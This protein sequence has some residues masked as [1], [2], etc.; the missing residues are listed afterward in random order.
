MVTERP[1]VS[2]PPVWLTQVQEGEE[3][4]RVS[5]ETMTG[6]GG[7]EDGTGEQEEGIPGQRQR[8]GGACRDLWLE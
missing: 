3:L 6:G 4:G 5:S 7:G 2:P 8:P 1:G